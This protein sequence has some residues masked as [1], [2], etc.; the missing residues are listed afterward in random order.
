NK[1]QLDGYCKDI[2]EPFD[3]ARKMEAF[4]FRAERVDGVD[5]AAIWVA[6]ER[7]RAA[8]GMP[9][10]IVLDTVKG[11]GIPYFEEMIDNHSVKFA[12]PDY[13]AA[14]EAICR[15]DEALG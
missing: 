10:C 4:G 8:H 1:R 7:A 14:R 3:L 12:D 13:R 11:Q 15:L 6:T 5:V 9:S 2:M